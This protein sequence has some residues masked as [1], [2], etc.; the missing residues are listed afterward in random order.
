MHESI[1][2]AII[3]RELYACIHS[4]F[5]KFCINLYNYNETI[6]I[7]NIRKCFTNHINSI[8]LII[9][10]YLNTTKNVFLHLTFTFMRK[11][12]WTVIF[13]KS[14]LLKVLLLVIIKQTSQNCDITQIPVYSTRFKFH[15]LKIPNTKKLP[16]NGPVNINLHVCLICD[17]TTLS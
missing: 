7:F 5:C 11:N 10:L 8:G 1:L 3:F 4:Y 12:I 16:F 2:F 13:F 6:Q 15:S 9:K 17:I 14:L